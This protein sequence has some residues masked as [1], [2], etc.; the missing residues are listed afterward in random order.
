MTVRRAEAFPAFKPRWA[1]K[2]EPFT[3]LAVSFAVGSPAVPLKRPALLG[4]TQTFAFPKDAG[5]RSNT[6]SIGPKSSG[7]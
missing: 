1:W 3:T 5:R 4:G 2:E 7:W 6:M